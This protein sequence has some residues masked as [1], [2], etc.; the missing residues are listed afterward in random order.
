METKPG[1]K[2]TEFWITLI[3]N[4]LSVLNMSGAW[5][6]T[7]NKWSVLTLAI[8]NGLYA[9]ARGLAKAGVPRQVPVDALGAVIAS[10]LTQPQ[11]PPTT[12]TPGPSSTAAPVG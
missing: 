7:P 12:A 3:T 6:F 9:V 8:V 10:R 2:T 5:N 11:R 1:M 4:V